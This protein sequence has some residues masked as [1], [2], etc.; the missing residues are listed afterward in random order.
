MRD[1][2]ASIQYFC[3]WIQK[4]LIENKHKINLPEKV[5]MKIRRAFKYLNNY[6]L[7]RM[8]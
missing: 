8:N 1:G 4:S 7:Q 3:Q 2:E 6:N 5:I